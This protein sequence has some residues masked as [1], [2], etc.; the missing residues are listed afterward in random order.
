M[1]RPTKGIADFAPALAVEVVSPSNSAVDIQRRINE[2]LT[3]GTDLVWVIYPEE[4][5]AYVYRSRTD[6]RSLTEQDSLD[7][8]Q[9]LPG[10]SIPLTIIFADL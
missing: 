8:G 3:A 10:L 4:R 6:V 2:W 7:G 1:G 5:Q 9:L